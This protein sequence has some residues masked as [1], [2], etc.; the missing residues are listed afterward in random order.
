MATFG[1]TVAAEDCGGVPALTDL[2]P[3]TAGPW[4]LVAREELPPDF[5]ERFGQNIAWHVL[6][7]RPCFCVKHATHWPASFSS[8]LTIAERCVPY[9][10]RR[11][12]TDNDNVSSSPQ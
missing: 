4:F 12:A 8:F 11:R 3:P 1:A 6:A 9:T 7:F 5:F 2:S 10:T